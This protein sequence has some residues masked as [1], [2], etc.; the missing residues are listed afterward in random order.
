VDA[1][2][3]A[4]PVHGPAHQEGI[5]MKAIMGAL[6]LALSTF[7]VAAQAA[8]SACEARAAEKKLAGAAKDSFVKKCERDHAAGSSCAAKADEKKLVGAARNSFVTKCERDAQA[9]KS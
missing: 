7:T 9:P 4:G 2:A 6:V 1:T 5:G 8:G 3:V